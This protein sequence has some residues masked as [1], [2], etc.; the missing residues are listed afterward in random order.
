MHPFSLQSTLL[1]RHAQHVVL[2]HFPVALF[3]T[4]VAFDFLSRW[5]H[6]LAL[7]TTAYLNLLIAAI[8]TIPVIVTGVLA[9]QWQLEG[10]KLKGI[11]LLHLILALISTCLI[12]SV[13]W[14]H[15]RARR[16]Q[17]SVTPGYVL[18]AES[19]AV[20]TLAVTAHLGGFLS[21]V[22]A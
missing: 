6:R 18:L 17:T 13:L 14:L 10:Q 5:L 4:S 16:Q 3:M 22:N 2:I 7:K 20:I 12:W 8:S 9:W 1:A 21:G 11:L 19:V 15:T